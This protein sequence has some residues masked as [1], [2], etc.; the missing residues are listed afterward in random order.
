[1]LQKELFC[2]NVSCYVAFMFVHQ[3]FHCLPQAMVS[4]GGDKQL[5]F[6]VG[7]ETQAGFN[8]FIREF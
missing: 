2:E 8:V 6:A 7:G 5:A 3:L 4:R 1:L